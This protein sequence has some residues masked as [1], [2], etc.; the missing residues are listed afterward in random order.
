MGRKLPKNRSFSSQNA[1]V[2]IEKNRFS[3]GRDLGQNQTS[4][5]LAV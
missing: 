4:L 2:A 5:V 1:V 3:K